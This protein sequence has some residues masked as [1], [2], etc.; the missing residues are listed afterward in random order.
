RPTFSIIYKQK[1]TGRFSAFPYVCTLMNC[2]LWFFYGLP[3]ISENNILVLT[4]N[5]AGIVIE[6]VYL[7]IFIYYAAWPVKVRSIARVLLLFVI[8]FCAITFAITLGA[9]EGDDRTTFLGSINVI[10]NTMMYAAPLSVMKMVI[11]TKSVEYMPFMLSLCSFV[12]A[13]IWALY[14]I[15][16]QDKFIIIPNGL[17]VL[18]GALQLG[19]YAKY[20]K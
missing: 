16:K 14:G 15:L 20:R 18:L 17:G 9:F 5:G 4:I 19:L 1:D 13:T 11:E 7:V 8:F 12:N 2:L 10:I 6:A 3:I